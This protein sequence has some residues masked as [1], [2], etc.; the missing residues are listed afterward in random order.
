MGMFTE[1]YL[2]VRLKKDTP[3]NVID[4]LKYMINGVDEDN[5]EEV[6]DTAPYHPLF[7]T[8]MWEHMLQCRSYYFHARLVNILQYDDI[9]ESYHLTVRSDLKNYNDEILYFIDWLT[10]YI[11]KGYNCWEHLGHIR[12][13][14]DTLP[15]LIM[16]YRNV[17]EDVEFLNI[18]SVDKYIELPDFEKPYRLERDFD[19]DCD[20]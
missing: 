3:S 12:Y 10:P 13:E 14:E 19:V 6:P 16:G 2:G 4:I 20:I 11:V 15:E 9:S 1:L 8:R 18:V 5:G 17:K 7:E